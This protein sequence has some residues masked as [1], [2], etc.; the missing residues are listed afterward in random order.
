[1]LSL[2]ATFIGLISSFPNT[3]H[4]P[5]LESGRR[6]SGVL[7]FCLPLFSLF[8]QLAACTSPSSSVGLC[9][10]LLE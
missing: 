7:L 9:L 6:H 1:M 4:C 10:A 5:H 2:D 3:R 8:K